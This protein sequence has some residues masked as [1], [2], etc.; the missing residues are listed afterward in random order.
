MEEFS[1][2]LTTAYLT[3]PPRCRA[4]CW[5]ESDLG[6]DLLIVRVGGCEVDPGHCSVREAP[7]PTQT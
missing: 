4:L 1:T 6:L 7:E 2:H 3:A 5:D